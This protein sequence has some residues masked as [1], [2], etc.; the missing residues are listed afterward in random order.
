M[1]TN[2]WAKTILYVYKYLDRV[3]EGIDKLVCQNALNS[4][5]ARGD[6]Q[7][8][9]GVMAVADRL[10][11]LSAR[12]V[13]LINL[14]VLAD[15]SLKAIDRQNAQLLIEKYIDNDESEVIALRHKLHIRTYFR[16]LG[17]AE[18]SFCQAMA[19]QGFDDK[20]LFSYLSQEKWILEVYDK[21]KSEKE[22]YEEAI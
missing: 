13:R 19:R 7:S 1:K 18:I 4:F 16:R 17:Q 15:N 8:E 20:R 22:C 2:E 10:I 14:K 9:N 12:K 21:F 6:K 3:T 11:K 5:Y